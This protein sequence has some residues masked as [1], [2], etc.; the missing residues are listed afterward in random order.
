MADLN[1]IPQADWGTAAFLTTNGPSNS[2]TNINQYRPAA[3][4]GTIG[5][6]ARG[7]HASYHSLQALFRSRTGSRSS[8]QVS[9]TYSHSI[10][11]IEEDNSSGSLNQEAFINPSNTRLDKGNTNINR[12]HIFVANEVLDLPTFAKSNHMLQQVIGGW[13]LNSIVSIQSGASLSVFTNGASDTNFSNTSNPMQIPGAPLCDTT[14]V[15]SF[16]AT[17]VNCYHLNSLTGTGFGNNQRANATG[18]ACNSG[19][20]GDQLLNPAAFTLVGYQIGTVGTARRGSCSGANA[21]N[22]DMQLAKNWK[23]HERYN[24]KFSM[25][26]FNLFNHANFKSGN[27]E[28][29]GFSGNVSCGSNACSPTNN[30]V[31]SQSTVYCAQSPNTPGCQAFGQANGVQPG[32]ELQYTLRFSF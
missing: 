17:S 6:F 18:I 22:I 32:R 24:L 5:E 21:R 11:D 12:P 27:L 20:H 31:T 25:D 9:Y 30:V 10:G 3:N 4:F 19:Q 23:I 26:F 15:T 1:R 14:S 29:T 8:F 2:V 7:G 28:G 16:N 13:E